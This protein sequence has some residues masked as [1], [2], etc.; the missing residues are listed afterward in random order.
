MR[1][2]N[3][4][5]G[6]FTGTHDVS[7]SFQWPGNSLTH[8]AA[9]LS[10]NQFW[11]LKG[12]SQGELKSAFLWSFLSY[13][14]SGHLTELA[15][16]VRIYFSIYA[17]VHSGSCTLNYSRW[18]VTLISIHLA[19]ITL[20]LTVLPTLLWSTKEFSLQIQSAGPSTGPESPFS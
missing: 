4:L 3:S 2:K 7:E 12:I 5:Y 18:S 20:L 13:S 6:S 10:D 16:R 11:S 14:H 1:C 19:L 8:K 9:H 15:E 17:A